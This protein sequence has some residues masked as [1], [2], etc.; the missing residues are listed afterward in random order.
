M[1]KAYIIKCPKC[2]AMRINRKKK[3]C[4][5]CGQR[6]LYRGDLWGKG[7]DAFHWMGEKRGWVHVSQ[8]AS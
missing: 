6:L 7:D 8:L 5:V 2:D 1:R 3:K 4:Q